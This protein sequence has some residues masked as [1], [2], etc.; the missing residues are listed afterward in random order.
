MPRRCP[1]LGLLLLEDRA[2]PATFAYAAGTLT[3]TVVA[4]GES[5]PADNVFLVD[6]NAEDVPGY[7][8]IS[9]G[10]VDLFDSSTSIPGRL[11]PVRNLVVN[12]GIAENYGLL[13]GSDVSLTNLAVRGARTTTNVGLAADTRLAGN[14]TFLGHPV[15]GSNG[16]SIPDGTAIGGDVTLS[17]GGGGNAVWL[18]GGRVGGNVRVTGGPAD[19]MVALT[20]PGPLTVGGSLAI[21]LRG[22]DNRVTGTSGSLVR[23]G[24]NFTYAGGAGDDE[25]DLS[26]WGTRLQVI[27]SA[28]A[29]LGGGDPSAN[30]WRTGDLTVGRNLSVRGAVDVQLDGENFIG[31]DATVTGVPDAHNLF[32]I[33]YSTALDPNTAASTVNGRLRYTGGN[34]VDTEDR[35]WLDRLTVRRNMDLR[36]GAGHRSLVYMGT[37]QDAGIAIGGSLSISNTAADGAD[38]GMY[39]LDRVRVDGRF[40]VRTLAGSDSVLIDDS[41]F[42]GAVMFDLGTADDFVR[43]DINNVDFLGHLLTERTRFQAGLT[44]YGRAGNDGVSLGIVGPN[45]A[46]N[47]GGPVRLVGGAGSDDLGLNATNNYLGTAS[48]DFDTGVHLPD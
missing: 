37:T 11:A 42:A 18:G 44:V 35:L 10:G 39:I 7:L 33:G 36:F 43:I 13:F 20:G 32:R 14:F 24:R 22:G 12:P 31:G 46:V 19:D 23:V 41:D 6:R 26:T 4:A 40:S 48:D 21:N 17:L 3:I 30:S 47:F 5:E 29:H 38:D 1:P 2:T 8:V 16:V 28:S 45:T 9:R 25:I 27:G 34:T 15:S